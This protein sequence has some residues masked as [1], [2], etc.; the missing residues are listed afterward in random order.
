MEDLLL[1]SLRGLCTRK[2]EKKHVSVLPIQYLSWRSISLQAFCN[3]V[4]DFM[5]GCDIHL[6]A[7]GWDLPAL[8]CLGTS[9]EVLPHFCCLGLEKKEW[10]K[11]WR[12]KKG[13][14]CLLHFRWRKLSFECRRRNCWETWAGKDQRRSKKVGVGASQWIPIPTS[15]KSEFCLS[16]A[17]LFSDLTYFFICWCPMS[18]RKMNVSKGCLFC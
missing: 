14:I 12:G 17:H 1:V 6:C 10:G 16:F 5:W 15:V 9:A 8:C 4:L 2:D 7:L 3:L 11:S 13:N 18:F